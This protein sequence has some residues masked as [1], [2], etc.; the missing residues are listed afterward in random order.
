MDAE[1]LIAAAAVVNAELLAAAAAGL[2]LAAAVGVVSDVLSRGVT[3][4]PLTRGGMKLLRVNGGG[5]KVAEGGGGLL[6]VNGG[7]KAAEDATKLVRV[8][9]GGKRV[10]V[11]GTVPRL[12]ALTMTENPAGN[13]TKSNVLDEPDAETAT[14]EYMLDSPDSEA[15]IFSRTIVTCA[16]SFGEHSVP[17]HLR[18]VEQ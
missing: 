6:R 1:L 2:P 17:L 9:G 14:G 13:W 8:N 4:R 12:G 5:K 18:T 7:G 10:V 15:Q 11:C 16:C 3:G